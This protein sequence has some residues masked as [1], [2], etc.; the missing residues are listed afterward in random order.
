MMRGFLLTLLALTGL[1]GL[2]PLNYQ[3]PQPQ[4]FACLLLLLMF[5]IGW[6]ISLI[7]LLVF[8][9]GWLLPKP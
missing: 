1:Y 4:Y 2:A 9:L 3:S 8:L 5:W 7:A 6:M